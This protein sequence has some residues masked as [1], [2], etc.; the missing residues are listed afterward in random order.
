[1]SAFSSFRSPLS[2]LRP[3]SPPTPASFW[4]RLPLPLAASFVPLSLFVAYPLSSPRTFCNPTL[5][6]VHLSIPDYARC[7]AR[8]RERGKR[9]RKLQRELP[10][11]HHAKPFPRP[12]SVVAV[13]RVPV[14]PSIVVVVPRRLRPQQARPR[15]P[16]PLLTTS[17]T[18]TT[19]ARRLRSTQRRECL[20]SIERIS[21]DLWREHAEGTPRPSGRRDFDLPLT[22]LRRCEPGR[23]A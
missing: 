20:R 16:L 23:E 9:Y 11:P 10:L 8:E 18:S 2:L 17:P 14:R 5:R 19:P 15:R 21:A 12:R 1:M 3:S 22:F 6:V 7:K 13:S 4:D